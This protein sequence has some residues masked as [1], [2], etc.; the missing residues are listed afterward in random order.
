ME[1]VFWSLIFVVSLVALVKGAGWLIVGAEKVGL[2]FGLSPFVIGVTIVTLGTSLPELVSSLSA[3]LKGVPEFV[4]STA[5][6][7]NIANILLVVGFAAIVG[8]KM[9][10]EKD[11]IDIDLPLA[12]MVTVLFLG[13]A[14]DGG[15]NLVE[16]L[17]LLGGYVLY[18]FYTLFHKDEKRLGRRAEILADGEVTTRPK[19][20]YLDFVAIGGGALVLVLGANYLVDSVNVFTTLLGVAPGVLAIS[21][22]AVGTSLPELVVVSRATIAGKSEVALGNI[23]GANIFN[24]LVVVGLPALVTFIPLGPQTLAVGLPM[25]VA[26]VFL[27][28]IVGISRQIHL[29][30]GSFLLFIYVVFI[31][32]LYGL[33]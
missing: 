9:A 28:V 24:L 26:A 18:I 12:A 11:L 2:S 25:L 8:K 15:V 29:W 22:V 20:S 32:K 4:S 13:V 33:F 23:F 3:V 5:I 21:V 16:A 7:S 17:I 30:E 6:G 31:A 1:I 14:W 27:F 10:V 19:I